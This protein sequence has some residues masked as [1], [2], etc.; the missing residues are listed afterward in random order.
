MP[1]LRKKQ[2]QCHHNELQKDASFS[3]ITPSPSP[4]LHCISCIFSL[5]PSETKFSIHCYLLDCR[6]SPYSL[7]KS[8]LSV[9]FQAPSLKIELHH[10]APSSSINLQTE[11]QPLLSARSDHDPKCFQC[12]F[13]HPFI[14]QPLLFWNK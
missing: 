5:S 2:Y 8:P 12:F 3:T 10:R 4:A 7:L 11:I 1:F 9:D 13:F 6:H 14:F